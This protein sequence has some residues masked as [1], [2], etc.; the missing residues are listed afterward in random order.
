MMV[1]PLFMGESKRHFT[2]NPCPITCMPQKALLYSHLAVLSYLCQR[3]L[4]HTHITAQNSSR[5]ERKVPP[6]RKGRDKNIIPWM[7]DAPCFFFAAL[8]IFAL[9]AFNPCPMM[10]V[11]QKALLHSR[12]AIVPVSIPL[13]THACHCT[14]EFMQRT[15]PHE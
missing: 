13:A 10:C 3:C 7:P 2:F 14:K 4:L 12:C 8:R 1:Q 5:K 6:R 11:P 9:F 15:L